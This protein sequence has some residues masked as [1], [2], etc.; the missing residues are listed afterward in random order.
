MWRR[1][2]LRWIAWLSKYGDFERLDGF[3]KPS[4]SGCCEASVRL[5]RWRGDLAKSQRKL[6]GNEL[7]R[8]FLE[9]HRKK[10]DRMGAASAGD[11]ALMG[12]RLHF[13]IVVSAFLETS[14]LLESQLDH[15]HLLL[16][17]HEDPY[18]H[19]ETFADGS[20]M[21]K[22]ATSHLTAG[23]LIAEIGGSLSASSRPVLATSRR[24][25]RRADSFAAGAAVARFYLLQQR[26]WGSSFKIMGH[27]RGSANDKH[28]VA[29]LAMI[30]TLAHE[31]SHHIMNHSRGDAR[32][33]HRFEFEADAS[34]HA[35][36]RI[37]TGSARLADA[38]AAVALL[39]VRL[40]E[41]GLLVRRGS[42]HPTAQDRWARLGLDERSA[43]I[44]HPELSKCLELAT[45]DWRGLPEYCWESLANSKDWNMQHLPPGEI[46]FIRNIERCNSLPPEEL[47]RA[48]GN[49]CGTRSL[50]YLEGLSR[51]EMGDVEAALAVWGCSA[52]DVLDPRTALSFFS[53]AEL[54][55]ES[56]GV[57]EAS[58]GNADPSF[59]N[60]LATIA[61]HRV[62]PI[63]RP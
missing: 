37:M 46:E 35:L 2:T 60:V 32:S 47:G 8:D 50:R 25:Q 33:S 31:L 61:A 40:H 27:E 63:V 53:L 14:M 44:C 1:S 18:C 49:I 34:A 59:P 36:L 54:L 24:R 52:E 42:T 22:I 38:G 29:E 17:D 10:L 16:L 19:T 23:I 5:E 45:R 13:G 6:E 43:V 26:L 21:I 58:S 41:Q 30:F 7:G 15:A 56:P 62:A 57:L 9:S 4:R 51:A 11:A 48:I 3:A 20:C 39:S 28:D 12:V 55:V